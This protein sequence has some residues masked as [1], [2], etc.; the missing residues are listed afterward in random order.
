MA[1]QFG[2]AACIVAALWSAAALAVAPAIAQD[3]GW[4]DYGGGAMLRPNAAVT[5][6]LSGY[7]WVYLS[8]YNG[9]S[10]GGM[11]SKYV[12]TFCGGQNI[13]IYTES[14]VS[15]NGGGAFGNSASQ[16]EDAGQYEVLEDKAGNTFL[17]MV[18]QKNGSK[19]M[20][21]RLQGVKFLADQSL[22][23]TRYQRVF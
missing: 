4:T 18:L 22:T 15:M 2:R 7:N 9:G 5:Q 10:G 17:H 11:A 1:V 6:A 16:D 23:F 8:S 12:A 14:S 20:H 13:H 21:F 19:F 3:G